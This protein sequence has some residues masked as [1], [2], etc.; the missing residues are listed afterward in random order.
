MPV[1]GELFV[2]AGWLGR[3]APLDGVGD[4]AAEVLPDGLGATEPLGEPE[5]LGEG[6]PA[7]CVPLDLQPVSS[8][9]P[10]AATSSASPA[11]RTC[12]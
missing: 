7:A 11:V 10:S 3:G 4:G 12:R 2:G 9:P 6:D 5:L 8:I 1:A